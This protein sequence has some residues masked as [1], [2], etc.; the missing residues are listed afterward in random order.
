MI[1]KIFIPANKGKIKTSARGFWRDNNKT[2]YDYINVQSIALQK[3]FLLNHISALQN[4]YNQLAMFYIQD[5]TAYIYTSQEK[6]EALTKR[7]IYTVK[8]FKDLRHTIKNC[9]AIYGGLTVYKLDNNL[10]NIECW[11]A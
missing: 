2:Y 11:T 6:I 1:A 5:N 3:P 7:T 9:L 8:G 4:E 10:Y